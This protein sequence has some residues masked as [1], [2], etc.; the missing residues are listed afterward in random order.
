MSKAVKERKYLKRA[1]GN[2]IEV[3]RRLSQI[4]AKKT[5]EMKREGEVMYNVRQQLMKRQLTVNL[6]GI[7]GDL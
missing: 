5:V 7:Y 3:R 2:G 6:G 4:E 1:T